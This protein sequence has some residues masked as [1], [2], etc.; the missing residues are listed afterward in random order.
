[1][2]YQAIRAVFE[3]PVINALAALADPVVVYVDNQALTT[4]DPSVEYA[5]MRLDFGRSTADA[6]QDKLENI[7]GSIVFEFFT[8]KDTGPARAQVV[9]AAAAIALNNIGC[10]NG[11]PAVGAYGVTRSMVGPNFDSL[12]GSPFFTARL[13]CAFSAGF[14]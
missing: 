8:P 3:V 4:T 14:N 13:S 12:E 6:L 2:S 10:T 11:Q 7:R 9:S 5:L 1:M